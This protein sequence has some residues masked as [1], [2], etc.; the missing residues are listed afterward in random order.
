MKKKAFLVLG[1]VLSI[2]VISAIPLSANGQ[3]EEG[4]KTYKIGMDISRLSID[5]FAQFSD[6]F[7]S[8]CDERGW[9]FVSSENK[10]DSAIMVSNLENMITAGCD[11]I[12]SQNIDPSASRDIYKRIVD[13]GCVLISYDAPSEIAD[14]NFYCDNYLLG[15]AVG[16]MAGKWVNEN[17]D[18][19]AN[20]I[21]YQVPFAEFLVTRSE[22]M[23]AGFLDTCENG[24]LLDV[25]D[26]NMEIIADKVENTLQSHSEMNVLMFPGD[27]DGHIAYEIL[28]AEINRKGLNPDNYGIFGIDASDVVVP[29]IAEDTIYRGS[30][31]M[32][33]KYIIPHAACEAIEYSLTGKGPAYE[34]E[35]F[36]STNPVTLENAAEIMK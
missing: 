24:K 21:V 15:Y 18:G 7:Q 26:I 20:A 23:Q 4:E 1:V 5:T 34:K 25:V 36:Y 11:A 13:A 17:M 9:K 8:Y 22:G 27:H 31:D 32:G 30:I 3:K 28:Q 6:V 2:V 10:E 33:L 16:E 12:F 35:N 19:K 14:Y 29:L